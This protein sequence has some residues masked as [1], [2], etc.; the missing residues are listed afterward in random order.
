V[1]A[2]DVS[3][4]MEWVE[5]IST[6]IEDLRSKKATFQQGDLV[7]TSPKD[8]PG[9]GEAAPVWVP[10]HRV[11]MCQNCSID[12]TLVKRRHHCR[13]CG[14]VLCSGCCGNKAPLKFQQ[15]KADKVC[16][17]CYNI[18]EKELWHEP[19]LRPRFERKESKS[20]QK[21]VPQRLKVRANDDGSQ[22]SGHLS[23][24]MRNGKWEKY[25]FVLKEWVLYTYRAS[26]D[27]AAVESMPVVGWKLEPLSDR[28]FELYEGRAP[29]LVFQL[30]HSGGNSY[31]F[32]A[33]NDNLAE[34]WMNALREATTLE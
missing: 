26:E 29:G 28:N 10:D 5:A 8:N 17:S 30:R 7:I 6:A 3:E 19:Y 25:W 21:Y 34:K 13:A 33:E 32:A 4:R 16:D 1:R 9:I 23:R 2:R 31:V 11:T 12:F 14:K 18:I 15:Y 27:T 24:R 22:M 20:V